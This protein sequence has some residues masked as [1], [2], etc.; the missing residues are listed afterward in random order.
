M[1]GNNGWKLGGAH[2]LNLVAR[3]DMDALFL[4]HVHHEDAVYLPS[5]GLKNEADNM[6][7]VVWRK[8]GEGWIGYIGDLGVAEESNAIYL[9]MCGLEI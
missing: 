2:V 1:C 9:A 5:L 7:P 8:Y 4:D 6:S 3:Y